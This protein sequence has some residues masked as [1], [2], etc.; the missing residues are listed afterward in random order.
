MP[1]SWGMQDVGH[2]RAHP[3]KCML[4]ELNIQLM[5]ALTK[6]PEVNLERFTAKWLRKR[7]GRTLPRQAELVRMLLET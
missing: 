2:E 7:Y 3:S 4:G 5:G 1:G 6:N